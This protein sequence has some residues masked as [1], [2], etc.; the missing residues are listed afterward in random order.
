MNSGQLSSRSHSSPI[1]GGQAELDVALFEMFEHFRAGAAQHLQLEP[2]EQLAQLDHV[3]GDHSD[4]S[5]V[6]DTA[7]LS[8]PTSPFLMA[9]A[10]ERALMALS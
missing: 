7:S 10:S 1:C 3:R 6:C 5:M 9:E 4:G 8:E 2:L